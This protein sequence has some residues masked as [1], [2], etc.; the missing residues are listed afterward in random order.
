MN[1]NPDIYSRYIRN[2]AQYLEY[3]GYSRSKLSLSYWNLKKVLTTVYEKNGSLPWA[4]GTTLGFENIYGSSSSSGKSSSS[5]IFTW[6]VP[7]YVEKGISKKDQLTA[8]FAGDDSTHNG[9]HGAIDISH[10]VNTSAKIVAAAAGKVVGVNTSCTHD[11]GKEDAKDPGGCGYGFGNYVIIEH[12]N[13]YYTL[14]GHMTKDIT[15]KEGDEVKSGQ[16]IG[17]MGSTGNSTGNHLHFEVRTGGSTFW[18][19]KKV[20]P[21]QFFNDDCSPVGGGSTS[22]N[23]VQFVWTWEGS[24]EY[25][26][27]QGHLTDDGKYYIIYGDSV[28]GT[29]AVGHGIDLDAG[30]F[31]SVFESNGYST[32][33]GSKVPKEFVDNLSLQE[34]SKRKSEIEERCKDLNLKDYQIDALVSRSYQ[35]GAYGWY[36]G[37]LLGGYCLGE[38]FNTAYQKWW[39]NGQSDRL[40]DNFM[41]YTTNGGESGLIKRRESE[42]KLF[43]TGVYD[44][45]H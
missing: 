21:E 45:S 14:Y 31:A 37:S 9:N 30:G 39:D 44:A 10:S 5:G 20:D 38:T 35:M 13:G 11:Y 27:S 43:K 24:D 12:S 2:G 15:V 36:D 18:N 17:I 34:L 28:A 41:R 7:E 4:Y 32:S 25:L 33:I 1:S 8:T 16:E 22:E 19:S 23:L 26:K 29:R 42:W 6:P 3:V 40:Y